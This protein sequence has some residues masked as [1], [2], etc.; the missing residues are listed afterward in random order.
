MASAELSFEC[1][2]CGQR[3]VGLPAFHFGGPAQLGAVPPDELAA[4]VQRTDDGCVLDLDGRHYFAR[5][6]LE[7][8]IRG[9]DER[10]TW[11]VWVSLSERSFHRY[12]ELF[13]DEQRPA[14]ESFFGWLCN[15]VPEYPDTM[16]L[17]TEL[18]VRPYP[19]RPLVE[20]E[21][22]GHPLAVDQREGITRE[23]AVALAE[24]LL[25]PGEGPDST[26]APDST[27]RPP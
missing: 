2:T 17:K 8:P 26:V 11:S 24:R 25:H 15:A 5:G 23:R 13:D 4:R 27:G 14:G 10:F 20:L 21:P 1:R 22:T 16:F 19:T 18:R 12:A 9:T 3:H 6:Q 7:I